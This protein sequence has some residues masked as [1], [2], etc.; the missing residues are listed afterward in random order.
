MPTKINPMKWFSPT[1]LFLAIAILIQLVQA[2]AEISF[3]SPYHS[4]NNQDHDYYQA[5]GADANANSN[6]RVIRMDL[7][8][9]S[10]YIRWL[11]QKLEVTT[12]RLDRNAADARDGDGDGVGGVGDASVGDAGGDGGGGGDGDAGGD[13]DGDGVIRV[14]DAADDEARGVADGGDGGDADA[15]G[16]D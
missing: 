6:R 14:G 12:G 2:A 4:I 1:L 10:S 9:T 3:D 15:R 13:V 5:F 7:H 8:P 16:A 11:Q